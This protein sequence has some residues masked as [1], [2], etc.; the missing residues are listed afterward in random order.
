MLDLDTLDW[1]KTAI[2]GAA[3]VDLWMVLLS[4]SIIIILILCFQ[5]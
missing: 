4:Y 1:V 3:L 2:G 5:Q